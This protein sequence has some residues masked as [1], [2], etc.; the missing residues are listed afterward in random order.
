[1]HW[2]AGKP[3]PTATAA[4]LLAHGANPNASNEDG[5]TAMYFAK[6]S[7]KT[8]LVTLVPSAWRKEIDVF[9]KYT[10]RRLR[11][12][13]RVRLL[14]PFGHTPLQQKR[15]LMTHRLLEAYG[16]FDSPMSGLIAPTPATRDPCFASTRPTT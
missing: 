8:A 14:P 13:G 10:P 7:G 1:M 2:P 11:L 6:A 5:K 4:L 3:V 15:L 9:S 12:H 16:A